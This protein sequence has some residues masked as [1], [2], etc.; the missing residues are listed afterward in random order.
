MTDPLRKDD[1]VRITGLANRTNLNGEFANVLED[2]PRAS[3]GRIG[4]RVCATRERVWIKRENLKRPT[5]EWIDNDGDSYL[6]DTEKMYKSIEGT[7]RGD[8]SGECYVC[9]VTDGRRFEVWTPKWFG[10]PG[11]LDFEPSRSR[12]I[13]RTREVAAR[14]CPRTHYCIY[15]GAEGSI[16]SKCEPCGFYRGTFCFPPRGGDTF[17]GRKLA[18][19]RWPWQGDPEAPYVRAGVTADLES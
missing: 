11:P 3:D 17:M 5:N 12:T 9:T 2:A 10:M 4:I 6:G 14:L 7:R 16:G 19:I 1:V 15:C 13:E 8:P 18:F